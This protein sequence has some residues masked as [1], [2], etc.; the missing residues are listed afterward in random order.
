MITIHNISYFLVVLAFFL[1]AFNQSHDETGQDEVEHEYY[2]E[3]NSENEDDETI[4]DYEDWSEH[5]NDPIELDGKTLERIGAFDQTLAIKIENFVEKK[6]NLGETSEKLTLVG[7][8]LSNSTFRLLEHLRDSHLTHKNSTIE[9]SNYL[10]ITESS[11]LTRSVQLNRKLESSQIE[12]SSKAYHALSRYLN[13]GEIYAQI[14]NEVASRPGE[15]PEE[16]FLNAIDI[17]EQTVFPKLEGAWEIAYQ[18]I[19]Q[20][21]KK[22]ELSLSFSNDLQFTEHSDLL[23]AWI[24]K[25]PN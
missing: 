4:N 16:I 2:D 14:S 12:A 11:L 23:K 22:K 7:L 19:N 6:R 15:N 3:W 20:I 18:N 10:E 5:E 9:R 24:P 17:L 21:I 13:F 1:G 8:I 25:L